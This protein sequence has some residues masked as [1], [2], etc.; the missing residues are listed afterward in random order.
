MGGHK[1][2][3]QATSAEQVMLNNEIWHHCGSP[4]PIPPPTHPNIFPLLETRR[5][6]ML[7][8]FPGLAALAEVAPNFRRGERI[9]FRTSFAFLSRVEGLGEPSAAGETGQLET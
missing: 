7:T 5:G 3:I 6:G 8:S 1:G 9:P 4:C 2:S